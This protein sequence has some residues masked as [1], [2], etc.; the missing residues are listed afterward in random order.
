MEVRLRDDHPTDR[1]ASATDR[2]GAASSDK[3]SIDASS[4]GAQEELV[5][6]FAVQAGQKKSRLLSQTIAEPPIAIPCRGGNRRQTA[7]AVID[8]IDNNDRDG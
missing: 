4:T 1:Q 8:C 2:P 5:G 3:S 6:L 7:P